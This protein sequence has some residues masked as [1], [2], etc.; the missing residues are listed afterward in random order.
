[1]SKISNS[2]EC[3]GPIKNGQ[4]YNRFYLRADFANDDVQSLDSPLYLPCGSHRVGTI[5]Q[6]RTRWFF[7]RGFGYRLRDEGHHFCSPAQKP[8]PFQSL[9]V[10]AGSGLVGTQ[11][12]AL[13]NKRI[14]NLRAAIARIDSLFDSEKLSSAVWSDLRVIYSAKLE[15]QLKLAADL[16]VSSQAVGTLRLPRPSRLFAFAQQ[17]THPAGYW[18]SAATGDIAAP[19]VNAYWGRGA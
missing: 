3:M 11:L 8:A 10:P 12:L 7:T 1:M 6:T 15:R 14:M 16:A 13:T 5:Y 19:H 9:A 18:V 4:D 17:L 2:A